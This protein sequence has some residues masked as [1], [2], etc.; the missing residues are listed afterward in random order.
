MAIVRTAIVRTLVPEAFL[1]LFCARL[2]FQFRIYDADSRFRELGDAPRI[3][4]RLKP[5]AKASRTVAACRPLA[6]FA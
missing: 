2:M 1:A 5:S 6:M 4:S 3:A